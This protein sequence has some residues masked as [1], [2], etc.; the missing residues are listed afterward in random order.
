MQPAPAFFHKAGAGLLK[1]VCAVYGLPV[2]RGDPTPP[3][4]SGN[5]PFPVCT[6]SPTHIF[7][8][9]LALGEGEG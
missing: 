9:N 8:D 5:M 2:G 1:M 4:A 6:L 3:Q 7:L